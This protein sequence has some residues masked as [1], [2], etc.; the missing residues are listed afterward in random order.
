M[1]KSD[2][3]R[4]VEVYRYSR[5]KQQI[6]NGVSRNQRCASPRA[7]DGKFNVSEQ[8]SRVKILIEERAVLVWALPVIATQLK[9]EFVL[10][11]RNWRKRFSFMNTVKSSRG[12]P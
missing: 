10:R 9:K 11:Y 1:L 5:T 7:T 6:T 4:G 12:A 2:I 8:V 3:R